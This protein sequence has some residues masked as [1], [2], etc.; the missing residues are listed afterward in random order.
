VLISSN[1]AIPG[2]RKHPPSS[3]RLVQVLSKPTELGPSPPAPLDD[4][5]TIQTRHL[6]LPLLTEK[7]DDSPLP[8]GKVGHS[9]LG[10]IGFGDVVSWLL[11]SPGLV[12]TSI[13][14]AH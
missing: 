5:I 7:T 14:V 11:P 2:S 9:T 8:I 12:R 1:R 4:G 10:R 6:K 13:L 3:T